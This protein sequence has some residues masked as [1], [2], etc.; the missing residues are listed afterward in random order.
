MIVEHVV[1]QVKPS[2]PD[3][4]FDIIVGQLEIAQ[5]AKNRIAEEGIVVRNIGGSIIPHPAI[6]VQNDAEKIV[7]QLV[8]KYSENS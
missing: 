6:K 3:A 2:T 7:A 4:I 8:G 1:D 5:D